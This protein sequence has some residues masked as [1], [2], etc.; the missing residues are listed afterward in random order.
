MIR[1]VYVESAKLVLQLN[2]P[3][4]GGFDKPVTLTMECKEG[5]MTNHRLMWPAMVGALLNEALDGFFAKLA[6]I[7]KCE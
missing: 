4:Q 5:N 6:E 7:K 2:I 3:V 1:D